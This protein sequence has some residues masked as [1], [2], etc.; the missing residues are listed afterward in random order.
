MRFPFV[1]DESAMSE[2]KFFKFFERC[3]AVREKS[4]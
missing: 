1:D 2:F 3:V 4:R